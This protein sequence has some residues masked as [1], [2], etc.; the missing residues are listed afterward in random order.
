MKV[1]ELLELRRKNWQELEGLCDRLQNRR[2]SRFT[3]AEL[4]R[5]ASLYR[6]A[7]ADLA[8]AD[9]YQLPPNTVEYL[10][11]LVGRAHN[12]LY[13]TRNFDFSAWGK[14]LL[15]DAPRLIFNDRCVQVAFCL[16][17]G[18]F[19]TSAILAYSKAMWPRY[20]DEMLTP[21]VIEQLETQFEN[22]IDGR[23]PEAN[24]L[25][26]GFYI[27]HNTGIGLK[28]FAGGL[29]VIPGLFVTL[30]NAAHLG[31]AFG[32]MA[33]PEVTEGQNFFHFVTAHGP[34]ELSAIVLSAGS[35]LR[36]GVAWLAPGRLSRL[37]SLRKTAKESMPLMGA[38]MCMFFFAALIEGFISPSGLPYGLKATVG[39]L[40]CGL[41]T[42]YF[43][44][45]GLPRR[46]L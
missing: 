20:A 32:Y 45:L 24:V 30:F 26:A 6:A 35:G 4:S 7:C 9:S 39:V 43:V 29:L 17:W 10:H 25:M 11:R 2:K 23:D 8:L 21:I 40:S 14:L 18:V 34:F 1:A 15:E 3:P 13:R 46:R 33:R 36:L 31:A 19:I 44:V 41:L 12:Q 16:F 22:P 5:F 42:F 28:C 37:A 27:Q 38:A